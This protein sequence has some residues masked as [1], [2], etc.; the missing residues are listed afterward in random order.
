MYISFIGFDLLSFELCIFLC[1]I[2][3]VPY[4]VEKTMK[5]NIHPK[6]QDVTVTCSCGNTFTTGSTVDDI[7]VDLCSVCHPFFTGEMR[8]VDV[9][10]RVE[11]FQAK[12]NKAKELQATK[13]GK[14]A[15]KTSQ[16]SPKSLREML[17]DF[18]KSSANPAKQ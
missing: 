13:K 6:W 15:Q 12:L 18:K 11:R 5:S 1:I 2:P 10:G 8:F 14:K 7:K 3:H 17:G 9:Q 16:E 4:K